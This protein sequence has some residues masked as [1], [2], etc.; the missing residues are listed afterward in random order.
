MFGTWR[1]FSQHNH[2]SAC[3]CAGG[4]LEGKLYTHMLTNDSVYEQQLSTPRPTPVNSSTQKCKK[5]NDHYQMSDLV[6]GTNP[7]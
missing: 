1:A 3:F 6:L 2:Q 5:R 4:K 7:V